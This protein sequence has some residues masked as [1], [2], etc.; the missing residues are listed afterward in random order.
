[1]RPAVVVLGFVLGSA[2]AITFALGGTAIVFLVLRGD[3]PRLE[4]EIGPLL[5]SLGLFV[6]LT[7]GAAFSFYGEVKGRPWRRVAHVALAGLLAAVAAYHTWL[8]P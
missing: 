5:Q 6:L 7:A 4:G 2:T 1:M 8:R 3:Y